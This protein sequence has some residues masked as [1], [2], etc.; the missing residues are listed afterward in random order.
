MS[1]KPVRSQYVIQYVTIAP[2]IPP[3]AISQLHEPA[4]SVTPSGDAS[5]STAKSPPAYCN[6]EK[7]PQKKLNDGI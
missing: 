7:T 4:L 3:S 1:N 2:I 5:S 6:K